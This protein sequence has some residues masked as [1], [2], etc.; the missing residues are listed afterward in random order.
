MLDTNLEQTRSQK[1]RT[2]S[3]MPDIAN[4]ANVQLEGTINKVGMTEI[5]MPLLFEDA[6]H[7]HRTPAMANIFVD[8]KDPKAKG[9]H[10]SRL[11]LQLRDKLTSQ[12]FDMDLLKAILKDSLASHADI[13]TTV[14]LELSFEFLLRQKSLVSSNWGWR[15][16]PIRIEAQYTDENFAA[17]LYF[18]IPYSSTCP[19]SAAL[20]RQLIQEKFQKD[21]FGKK[22]DFEDVS[23]WLSS[24]QGI[25][26]TPHSQRSY[27]EVK[28][29][30]RDSKEYLDFAKWIQKV[31]KALGTPVQSAVKREDEQEF[32]LRNG[33]NLMFCEDAARKVKNMLEAEED[34]LSYWAKFSHIESLHPHNAVSEIC[35]D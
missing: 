14:Y 24:D 3:S 30:L 5:E 17:E 35:S 9:I 23:Q 2:K 18:E 26:A 19:C 31:E 7:F 22:L 21:F 29:K 20:A 32:A 34:I 33:Q 10:M 11:Y 25:I 13:S 8:L 1:Q 16:Y 4:S 15:S 27:A 12:V 28:I 6:G